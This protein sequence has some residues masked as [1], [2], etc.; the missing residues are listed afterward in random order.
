MG[1]DED[2]EDAADSEGKYRGLSDKEWDCRAE[3]QKTHL[4]ELE[5]KSKDLQKAQDDVH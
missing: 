4:A 2:D 1:D 3:T 5:G